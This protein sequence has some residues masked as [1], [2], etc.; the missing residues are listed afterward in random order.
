MNQDLDQSPFEPPIFFNEKRKE[1]KPAMTA[2]LELLETVDPS[3]TPIYHHLYSPT[4]FTEPVMK[5]IAKYYTTD[6]TFL[7]ETQILLLNYQPIGVRCEKQEQGHP[8]LE[9]WKN[10]KEDK[11]FLDKYGYVDWKFFHFLNYSETFLQFTSF[12]NMSSPVLSLFF[13]VLLFII[14]FFVIKL[15]GLEITVKEYTQVLYHVIQN[16][17][18]GKL[19]TQ[20]G[21]V[22]FDQKV[23][24]LVSVAFYFFSI[25]QNILSCIRFHSNMKLIHQYFGDM[26]EYIEQTFERI[27]NFLSYSSSLETYSLFN[28]KLSEKKEIL[29]KW[30]EKLGRISGFKYSFGKL[31]EIGTILKEFFQVYESEELNDA[32]Q[33][34][35]GFHGYLDILEGWRENLEAD[36]IHFANF[37]DRDQEKNKKQ[38]IRKNYYPVVIHTPVKNDVSLDKSLVVTGP[39]ASGKTTL[40]KSV[41]I[42]IL[43]SQQFGCGFYDS[44]DLQ[45][46][47]VFH[48]YLN[49]PD[50]SGRDSLFQAEARRCKEMIDEMESNKEENH[51]CILDEIYSGTNPEEAT[52]SAYAFMSYILSFSNVKC[53]LTTHFVKV[54][55]KLKKNKRIVNYHMETLERKGSSSLSEKEIVPTYLLKKGISEVKGGFHVLLNMGYPIQILKCLLLK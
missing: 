32:I 6:K 35:F 41:I 44:A 25:Y 11:S 17:A 51:F 4:P 47:G 7:E 24:L 22:S 28:E 38:K 33:Y 3:A 45:L 37:I 46:Y 14:P 52:S 53:M 10:I 20:F 21:S 12:Y 19:F 55:K 34:S 40:I 15:K 23:Y 27:D 39:N 8:I 5:K 16:H 29:R 1:V 18:L 42:N 30:R 31:M 49:I 54:C 9:C 13:P 43:F 36:K 26:E 48:S 2:D 50:T